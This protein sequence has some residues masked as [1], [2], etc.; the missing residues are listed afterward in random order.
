[1]GWEEE[2][3][4]RGRGGE[5]VRQVWQVDFLHIVA[6]RGGWLLNEACEGVGGLFWGVEGLVEA[7]VAGGVD[8]NRGR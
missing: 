8:R 4:D 7:A 5:S 6:G 3:G 1:M 2:G